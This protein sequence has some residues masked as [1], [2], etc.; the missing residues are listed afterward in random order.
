MWCHGAPRPKRHAPPGGAWFS[1]GL[2]V[3]MRLTAI[4]PSHRDRRGERIDV[5]TAPIGRCPAFDAC[6][7][8]AELWGIILLAVQLLLQAGAGSRQAALQRA[9]RAAGYRCRLI[10]GKT[11]GAD[12]YQ[13]LALDC[14][15]PAEYALEVADF[16][17]DFLTAIDRH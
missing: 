10:I 16:Y 11:A 13:G 6:A 5:R 15:Q 3:N 2:L 12:Q 1:Q 9:D 17:A 14:R 8:A 7:R 4:A